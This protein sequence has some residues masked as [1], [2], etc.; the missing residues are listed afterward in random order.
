MV[1]WNFSHQN[2]IIKGLVKGIG[3]DDEGVQLEEAFR[4][5]KYL[6][7]SDLWIVPNQPHSVHEGVYKTAFIKNAKLFFGKKRLD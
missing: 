4:T 6:P 7:H 1:I 3:D 5:R 2:S